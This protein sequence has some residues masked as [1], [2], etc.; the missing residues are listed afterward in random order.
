MSFIYIIICTIFI[1]ITLY[2]IGLCL[3]NRL[4]IIETWAVI[5]RSH[6]RIFIWLMHII[7]YSFSHPVKTI[8]CIVLFLSSIL[9]S[10]LKFIYD[11]GCVLTVHVILFTLFILYHFLTPASINMV[12]KLIIG[13]A[14]IIIVITTSNIYYKF[15]RPLALKIWYP[16]CYMKRVSYNAL[17]SN[18]PNYNF[19]KQDAYSSPSNYAKNC[20]D[21]YLKSLSK[22]K[23]NTETSSN[24]YNSKHKKT[25][26]DVLY[27]DELKLFGFYMRDFTPEELSARKRELLKLYHPDNY[28]DPSKQKE[29]EKQFIEINEAD[30]R[31]IAKLR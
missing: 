14:A 2:L 3:Y 29:H 11:P 16:I 21:E 31:L 9:F 27:P 24:S 5:S 30:D 12:W 19:F 17:W 23:Q 15:L 22:T 8:K 26:L 18:M 10:I 1:A 28:L 20:A 13:I 25:A 6:S 7:T 4:S